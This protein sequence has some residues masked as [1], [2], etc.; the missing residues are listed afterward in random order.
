MTD[1]IRSMF[2][3]RI[4][5]A[6]AIYSIEAIDM[7]AD[8]RSGYYTRLAGVDGLAIYY[9]QKVTA[10]A[11]LSIAEL[12]AFEMDELPDTGNIFDVINPANVEP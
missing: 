8:T 1:S 6:G 9:H 10:R 7:P 11:I 2:Q 12:V 4:N 5:P 3:V